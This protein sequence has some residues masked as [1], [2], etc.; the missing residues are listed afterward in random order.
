MYIST[1]S[2]I[3]YYNP[4][5]NPP[6]NRPPSNR[7]LLAQGSMT[8]VAQGPQKVTD[9]FI[10]PRLVSELASEGASGRLFSQ[11]QSNKN[12]TRF[13]PIYQQDVHFN[14]IQ[15]RIASCLFVRCHENV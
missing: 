11:S 14:L 10:A 8:I 5:N 12:A 3:V 7:G 4:L 15:S 2:I 9:R 13:G 6:I 1:I